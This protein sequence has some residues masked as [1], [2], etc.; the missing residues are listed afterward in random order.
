MQVESDDKKNTIG[1]ANGPNDFLADS[2][3]SVCRFERSS[4]KIVECS[5][6]LA[7]LLG[8]SNASELKGRYVISLFSSNS[9][10][11]LEEMMR[12]PVTIGGVV[13]QLA[14]KDANYPDVV[15][16]ISKEHQQ[17]DTATLLC[18]P[19][20]S[21]IRTKASEEGRV[22]TAVRRLSVHTDL[23]RLVVHDLRG[24][25]QV[26]LAA[27]ELIAL[28]G[29]APSEAAQKDLGRIQRATETMV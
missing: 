13:C 6:S 5:E 7:T 19:L 15:V 12:G 18:L 16:T 10:P 25:V 8:C 27:L 24:S 26:I 23:T 17:G 4:L 14:D 3:F 29:S 11:A 28:K 9:L 2:P 1:A 21:K 22:E 20:L